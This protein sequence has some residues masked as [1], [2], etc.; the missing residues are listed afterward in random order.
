MP[1]RRAQAAEYNLRPR[2]NGSVQCR[3][4]Q[5]RH[6]ARHHDLRRMVAVESVIYLASTPA[7]IP[8]GFSKM[9]HLTRTKG[10]GPIRAALVLQA[11]LLPFLLAL[12]AC[13]GG[14][15]GEA[16]AK[17]GEEEKGPEGVA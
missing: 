12:A 15:S 13:G 9:R 2:C 16:Q 14:G 10:R 6:A 5:N 8:L 4:P 11:G 3:N 17:A 1:C 7:Y